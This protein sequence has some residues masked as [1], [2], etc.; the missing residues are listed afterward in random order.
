MQMLFTLAVLLVVLA[1]LQTPEARRVSRQTKNSLVV[2]SN[3]ASVKKLRNQLAIFQ[4]ES[5]DEVQKDLSQV[6]GDEYR[7]KKSIPKE[8]EVSFSL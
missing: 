3:N 2:P 8:M 6:V 7:V 4:K 5:A 1:L